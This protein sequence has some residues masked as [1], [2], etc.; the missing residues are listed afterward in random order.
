MVTGL[1]TAG[2]PAF[3]GGFGALRAKCLAHG[4]GAIQRGGFVDKARLLYDRI[5]ESLRVR[6]RRIMG[7]VS[8]AITSG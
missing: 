3:A 2:L 6:A 1:T 5:N 4:K 7:F 8:H